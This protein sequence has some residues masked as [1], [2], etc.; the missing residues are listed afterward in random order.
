MPS[1]RL[2]SHRN[3]VQNGVVESFPALTGTIFVN[4]LTF[5][6]FRTFFRTG[7]CTEN[8]KIK[9]KTFTKVVPVR[10]EKLSTTPFCTE[11][12]CESNRADGISPNPLFCKV[13]FL[14]FPAYFFIIFHPPAGPPAFLPVW[15]LRWGHFSLKFAPN[16]CI[17]YF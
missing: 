7:N 14:G 13:I 1:A 16:Y 8:S 6:I 3:S 10:A 11:F 12:W 15:G 9:T 4:L 5:A 17:W 2:D